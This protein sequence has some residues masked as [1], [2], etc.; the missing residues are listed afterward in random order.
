MKYIHIIAACLLCLAVFPVHASDINR[1]G[2]DIYY[3]FH[4][5]YPDAGCPVY[6]NRSSKVLL[7]GDSLMQGIGTSLKRKLG[8][9]GIEAINA[10]KPS[11]GLRN[12]DYYDWVTRSSELIENEKPDLMI[13]CMGANDSLGIVLN[14]KAVEFNSQQWVT[15]YANRIRKILWSAQI[16]N[17][18]VIWVTIPAMRSD[19]FNRKI[20]KINEIL[21]DTVSNSGEE[22]INMS[23]VLGCEAGYTD[24]VMINNR[25][26]IVR[27]RDGI[28][29]TM[30]G[31]D[32]VSD[33][34]MDALTAMA[35]R[36]ETGPGTFFPALD[37]H[38]F[39]IGTRQAAPR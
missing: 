36:G 37:N 29:L 7:I 39:P 21:D 30:K 35:I 28:H 19:S 23:E 14:G 2:K 24:V 38:S 20:R 18:R 4:Y 17:I 22:L 1:F 27:T 32:L 12:L 13:V 26:T 6:K 5:Q 10:A 33:R 8:K 3:P 25:K 9:R 15:E 31:Y 11:T 34:I 16:N